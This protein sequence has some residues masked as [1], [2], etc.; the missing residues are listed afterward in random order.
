MTDENSDSLDEATER[1]DSANTTATV[2]PPKPDAGSTTSNGPIGVPNFSKDKKGQIIAD[3]QDNIRLALDALGVGV[4]YDEFA[5]RMLIEGLPD[6]GPVLD[7]PALDRLWL[8]ID[9]RFKFRPSR[10]FFQVFMTDLA[11]Q[12]GF[13]PVIDY[14][15]RQN[16]D[17]ENRLDTWLTTYGGAPDNE[18]TRAV[19]KLALIAAVRRVRRPG[20]KFDEMLVLESGQGLEKSSALAVLAIQDDWFTDDLPLN[21]DGKKVIEQTTGKWIIEA[22]DLS[23]MSKAE[24]EHLKAFLSRRRDRARLAYGRTTTERS[25][26]F[27]VI[28]TTNSTAYLLDT[29][30]NRRFW[31]VTIER[32]DLDALRRDRDQLW[33]EAASRE[34]A[35]E[36]IRL[37]P[38]LYAAAARQQEARRI[39]DPWETELANVLGDLNG[40][41]LPADVWLLLGMPISRREP[42]HNS[43]LGEV[44]RRLGFT[45]KKLRHNGKPVGVYVRG[46]KSDWEHRIFITIDADGRREASLEKAPEREFPF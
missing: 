43:R 5:D 42:R 33:A 7:D 9:E 16:W 44:M 8:V 6:Q 18:Y 20:A 41:L 32:F 21:S 24:I 39:E 15:D 30:G 11:R 29:T 17:G 38:A 36:S 19:G 34:A 23:G 12:N 25:R 13:H 46:D 22:S 37:D 2:Y 45:R 40:R 27:I 14:I 3:S 1:M 28:G 31:P 10:F 26:H 4:S 35:G